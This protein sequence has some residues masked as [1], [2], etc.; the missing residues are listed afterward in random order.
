MTRLRNSTRNVT[1][2]TGPAI[3]LAML[4][5]MTPSFA[6]KPQKKAE[7]LAEQLP[8][9]VRNSYYYNNGAPNPVKVRLGQLLFFDKIL[10]GN[11]NTS[12]ATCH[13]PLTGIG[14]GL[15]LSVGEGGRGLGVTRSTGRGPDK[16]HE[17]VPRNAPH[18]F[19]LGARQFRRMF[20]DGRVERK[21][22][23]P[24]GILSPAGQALP[25]GLD[26][27]LAAQ[28]MFPVTSPTEMAGQ[29]GENEVADAAVAGN[30]PLVW[31]LLAQRLRAIPEY[32]DLFEQAFDDVDGAADIRYEH[33]ANAIAAFEAKTWRADNSPFDRFL[34]GDK[35]AL[36]RAAKRGMKLFYGKFD[37]A[38][39]HSGA[40]QT[41]HKF[42]AVAIPQIGP[43]K[44][45][46]P[47][48]REDFG[49]ERV[50]GDRAHR[51]KFRTPSLRNVAVTGPWGH[52]GAYSDL[53]AIVLHQLDPVA[54]LENY[55]INQAVLPSRSDLDALDFIVQGDASRRQ[56]IADA[57]ELD[58]TEAP[59]LA[60][61]V[62]DLLEFLY[63]LTDPASLDMNGD[64][65]QSVPSGLPLAE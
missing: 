7:A 19:N 61:K 40:F 52:D 34:R 12:C 64:V 42:H 17:R 10:S 46:S 2:Y 35:R 8:A 55:D 49:R 31:E 51:Y 16:I 54:A 26:N 30:L 5:G 50:T 15:S 11:L 6:E 59:N 24:S 62:D 48:G 38:S 18:V 9:P 44:G 56:A 1:L 58:A 27:P 29:E 25:D 65:P 63:A 37:C 60:A 13:H 20:H 43:G 45:D 28:A 41:D 32:V 57:C 23:F 4:V 21:S 22:G 39:C 53:R 47:D 3:A 33:A 14:D 36:S